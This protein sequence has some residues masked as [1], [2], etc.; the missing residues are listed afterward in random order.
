MYGPGGGYGFFSG[1]DASR[2]F[3]TGCFEEDLTSDL[4][5][6]EEMF[7][8][9]ED[10]PDEDIT[11]AQKKIRRERERRLARQQ[12]EKTIARWEGF[13]RNHRKYFQVGRVVGDDGVGDESWGKRALCEAAQSQRP[14][15]SEENEKNDKSEK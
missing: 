5:G 7:I 6:V 14:K 11:N 2:A 13:F 3:V 1:R 12:V 9:V 10:V 4:V 8:P 15:R